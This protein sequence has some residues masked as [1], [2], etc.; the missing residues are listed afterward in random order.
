MI[1]VKSEW[2]ANNSEL[3]TSLSQEQVCSLPKTEEP[4]KRLRSREVSL[5]DSLITS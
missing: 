4:H 1:I 5:I 2:A 3:G